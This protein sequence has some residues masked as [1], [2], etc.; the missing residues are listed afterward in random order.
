MRSFTRKGPLPDAE[1]ATYLAEFIVWLGCAW[2]GLGGAP[3]VPHFTNEE[4]ETPKREVLP[5]HKVND[6]TWTPDFDPLPSN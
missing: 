4:A 3:Q 2:L 6:R 5:H 1:R